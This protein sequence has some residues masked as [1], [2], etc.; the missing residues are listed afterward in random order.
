MSQCWCVDSALESTR[1]CQNHFPA[2][3]QS[4][5]KEIAPQQL[6]KQS[7]WVECLQCWDSKAL[8]IGQ[9]I[10]HSFV[11]P[12]FQWNF[13]QFLCNMNSRSPMSYQHRLLRP[14]Q[15]YVGAGIP[16][17][18][19]LLGAKLAQF[20]SA[21]SRVRQLSLLPSVFR[22]VM[23]RWFRFGL[24]HHLQATHL[25]FRPTLAEPKHFLLVTQPP[26]RAEESERERKRA[27]ERAG[28]DLERAEVSH[29]MNTSRHRSL[30]ALL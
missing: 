14:P 23:V 22:G 24:P 10:R 4:S 2:S 27:R 25:V 17:G 19:L 26:R 16:Q 7:Q 3:L 15:L 18:V 30:C 20:G 6:P 1:P 11:F 5:F 9:D 29:G 13:I 21:G 8:I 28:I 12:C